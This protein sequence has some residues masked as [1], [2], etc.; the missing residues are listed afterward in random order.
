MTEVEHN[1]PTK[2]HA[3]VDN[4]IAHYFARVV[5]VVT[6]ATQ[7]GIQAP[8]DILGIAPGSVEFAAVCELPV[9]LVARVDRLTDIV[10]AGVRSDSHSLIAN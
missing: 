1:N 10:D 4:A 7:I 8:R 9:S 3:M 2:K 5:V 6:T